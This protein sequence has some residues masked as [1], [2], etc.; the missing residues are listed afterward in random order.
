MQLCIYAL[1]LLFHVP[2][3]DEPFLAPFEFRNAKP[4][5]DR[6]PNTSPGLIFRPQLHL[7]SL[8]SKSLAAENKIRQ[9]KTRHDKSSECIDVATDG[10]VPQLIPKPVPK[11]A[12]YSASSN[13]EPGRPSFNA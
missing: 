10:L 3:G 11:I 8:Q 1:K 7:L 12:Q 5:Q 2:F 4:S 6:R 13:G 9:D